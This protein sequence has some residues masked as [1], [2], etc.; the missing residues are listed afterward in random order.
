M[1]S[2]AVTLQVE[3]YPKERPRITPAE[4]ERA[5]SGERIKVRPAHGYTPENTQRY[6]LTVRWLLRQAKV[7]C[8]VGDLGADVTFWYTPV[9]RLPRGHADVDNYVKALFDACNTIGWRD[10]RQVTDVHARLVA[11]TE[12][13][14][15]CIEFAVWETE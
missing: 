1:T 13:V 15:P 8:L 14:K 2:F 10:D 4:Y 11:V 7:P 6:E 3:P 9:P 12:G 5:A